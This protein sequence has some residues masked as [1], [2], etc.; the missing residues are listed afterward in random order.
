MHRRD[1]RS[2][3]EFGPGCIMNCGHFHLLLLNGQPV[4]VTEHHYWYEGK[5]VIVPYET[6]PRAQDMCLERYNV[7]FHGYAEISSYFENVCVKNTDSCSTYEEKDDRFHCFLI[8][9]SATIHAL[10]FWRPVISFDA[11]CLTG[12][13]KGNIY[14]AYIQ[15]VNC[16]ILTIAFEILAYNT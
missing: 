9:F 3:V 14:T 4:Q 13:Y 10:R 2:N 11:C 6:A 7:S 1:G 16:G 15:D 8:Y 12:P 5:V